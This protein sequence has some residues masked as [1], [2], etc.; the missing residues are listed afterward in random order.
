MR[1]LEREILLKKKAIYES[2]E[3]SIQSTLMPYYRGK[4]AFP[5]NSVADAV[6]SMPGPGAHSPS[7]CVESAE[8]FV[9]T[10]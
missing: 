9:L 6:S 5:A 3:L 10:G 2:L 4:A 7:L 8:G 1:V